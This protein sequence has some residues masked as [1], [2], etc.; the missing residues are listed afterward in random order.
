MNYYFTA[1]PPQA[2][3]SALGIVA[4]KQAIAYQIIGQSNVRILPWPLVLKSLLVF[5]L[6]GLLREFA[7]AGGEMIIHAAHHWKTTPRPELIGI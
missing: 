7:A 6:R 5:W 2:D 1:G 3:L 4:K